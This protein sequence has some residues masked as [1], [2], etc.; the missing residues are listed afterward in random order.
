MAGTQ[1]R[2]VWDKLDNL[3]ATM[4][5]GTHQ[6]WAESEL[7]KARGQT[8]F[9]GNMQN[10]ALDGLAYVMDAGSLEAAPYKKRYE[11]IEKAK[12]EK[13]PMKSRNTDVWSLMNEGKLP[14]DR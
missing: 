5:E 8:G 10:E 12:R 13:D 3:G 6:A 1:K 14:A 7:A 9:I 4:R 2:S 11:L